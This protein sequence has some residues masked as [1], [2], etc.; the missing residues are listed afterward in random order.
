MATISVV[1]RAHLGRITADLARI[2]RASRSYLGRISVV[3]RAHHQ[4]IYP[5]ADD[6]CIKCASPEHIGRSTW[7]RKIALAQPSA[8]TWQIRGRPRGKYAW[9]LLGTALHRRCAE[10]NPDKPL[11]HAIH[12]IRVLRHKDPS[13]DGEAYLTSMPRGRGGA[14]LHASVPL[15]RRYRAGL[16]PGTLQEKKKH[17]AGMSSDQTFMVSLCT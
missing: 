10:P 15:V 1:S 3:S 9:F 6:A 7:R 12:T 16:R 2:S 14:S 5:D 8:S 17:T 13:P 11:I 4:K